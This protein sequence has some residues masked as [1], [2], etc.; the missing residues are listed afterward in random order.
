VRGIGDDEV[1]GL[2]VPHCHGASHGRL[3][4]CCV[5]GGREGD[6]LCGWERS[7]GEA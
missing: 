5:R 7:R 6:E 1:L 4:G 2:D 3:V